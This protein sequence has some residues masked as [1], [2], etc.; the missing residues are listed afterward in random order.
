MSG[1]HAARQILDSA[2]PRLSV[3]DLQPIPPGFSG[4]RVYRV[5][6]AD[7][8]EQWALRQWHAG[9]TRH[10][11]IGIHRLLERIGRSGLCQV[12]VP[13]PG[14]SGDTVFEVD[15][16]LWQLEPWM[17][18]EAEFHSDPTDARLESA[19]HVIAR[20]HLA[21]AADPLD[22]SHAMHPELSPSPTICE[23]ADLI[24]DY[25]R[26][27]SDIESALSREQDTRFREAAVRITVQFRRLSVNVQQQLAAVRSTTVP[28]QSC[29]RDLWHDHLLFTGDELTGL[30]DFGAV[31]T[32]TV[33]CDLSRL[34]GSLFG[35]DADGWRRALLS[36]EAVR[37]LSESESAL[38]RP[39]DRS[40][41]LLSGMT[42]LKRRYLQ[43]TEIPHLDRVSERIERIGDR[44]ALMS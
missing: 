37:P 20:W 1:M 27:L 8:H 39:L 43:R 18:G 26:R 13:S 5:S 2:W 40:G 28:L 3:R 9:M 12:P 32:D 10:R 7:G 21:A 14:I 44:L 30:V 25:Q 33:A 41:V 38:L 19:M 36:Y 24:G 22:R 15:G 16:K 11:L 42:W 6:A 31:R 35:N 17:P 34:L 29:I 4:A 23:R